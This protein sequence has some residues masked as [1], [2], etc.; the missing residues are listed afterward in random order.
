MNQ[1]ITKP[2]I[3]N[4]WFGTFISQSRY[5]LDI[6]PPE[7]SYTV[8]Q[9]VQLLCQG[10]TLYKLN[11]L[12]TLNVADQYFVNGEQ[13]I[14]PKLNITAIN[15]LC[16]KQEIH[17]DMLGNALNEKEFMQLVTKLINDGYWY[18]ND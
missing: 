5:E 2:H 10:N 9:V 7:P 8:E 12:R 15:I 6:A 16:E 17:A 14:S 13:L 3:F 1:L 18:F 4:N 11:G